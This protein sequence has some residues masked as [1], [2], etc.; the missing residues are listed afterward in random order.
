MSKCLE[1]KSIVITGAFG[2]LGFEVAEAVHSAGAVVAAIDRVEQARAPTFRAGI[3]SF[4]GIDLG[5]SGTADA[6]FKSIADTIG[7][8]DGLVN[9]AGGFRWETI[10]DGSIV[11]VWP[12]PMDRPDARV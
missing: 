3:T 8:V 11:S 4:G 7:K 1:G 12:R 5:I 9:V 2:S 10:A 6:A